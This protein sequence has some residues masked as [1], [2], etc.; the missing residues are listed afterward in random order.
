MAMPLELP[1]VATPMV[2]PVRVTVTTL[3]APTAAPVWTTI[4]V[5]VGV[6][7]APL[8]TPLIVAAGAPVPEKKPGGY[9]S[10]MLLP[11]ASAPPAVVVNEKVAAAEL[12]PA[13]RS[14]VA[15]A[16]EGLVT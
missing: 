3:L 11:D 9:V 15:I 8:L 12:L 16:N 13:T 14:D 7:T 10:V 2:R 5:L 1:A 6:E 4:W